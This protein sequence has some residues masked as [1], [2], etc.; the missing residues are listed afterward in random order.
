MTSYEEA[1]TFSDEDFDNEAA[2]DRIRRVRGSEEY[3]GFVPIIAPGHTPGHTCWLLAA[4]GGGGFMALLRRC[5]AW[6]AMGWR[7][8]RSPSLRRAS[9]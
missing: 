4:P 3:L 9:T 7:T 6:Q 8:W 5:S 2:L 1:I